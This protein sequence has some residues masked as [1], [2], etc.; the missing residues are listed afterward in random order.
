ML[1]TAT[2]ISF[3][4]SHINKTLTDKITAGDKSQYIKC[5]KQQNLLKLRCHVYKFVHFLRLYQRVLVQ[6]KAKFIIVVAFAFLKQQ[7]E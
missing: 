2:Y 4:S 3:Y 5:A 7:C 6:L 1:Y